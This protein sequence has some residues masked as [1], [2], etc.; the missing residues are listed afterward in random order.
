M[1]LLRLS[2][3]GVRLVSGE[4][5]E[6]VSWARRSGGLS[7]DEFVMVCVG[8]E[9]LWLDFFCAIVDESSG[10]RPS[11]RGVNSAVP[12]SCRSAGVYAGGG[13]LG[14]KAKGCTIGGGSSNI[15]FGIFSGFHRCSC[16]PSL[17]SSPVL[18]PGFVTTF[19]SPNG[20]STGASSLTSTSLFV[21]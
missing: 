13:V 11:A 7:G 14:R 12:P 10:S 8:V 21:V 1:P 17:P 6:G 9:G 18:T 2:F 16:L 15:D 20:L 4:D 5:E 3:G 19:S